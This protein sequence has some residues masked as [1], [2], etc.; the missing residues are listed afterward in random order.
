VN[1]LWLMKHRG[2][3][4]LRSVWL[5]ALV[6]LLP[7]APLT[8]PVASCHQS[9]AS[10][11]SDNRAP[12]VFDDD[13]QRRA[14]AL[15]EAVVADNPSLGEPFWFPKDPFVPLKDVDDPLGYWDFL[16]K[17]YAKDIHLEHAARASW[18]GATFDRFELSAPD[19]S[20]WI[21]P[22]VEHNNIGYYR[23]LRST[24]RYRVGDTVGLFPVE[25]VIT[26]QGRWFVTHLHKVKK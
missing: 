12:P 18:E 20:K 3:T 4:G 24:V 16:H 2:T 6:P 25:T 7:L 9:C 17:A 5:V 19:A 10:S 13:L 8:L 14:G 1:V 15:F 11:I 21:D 23:S 26:W 22:G